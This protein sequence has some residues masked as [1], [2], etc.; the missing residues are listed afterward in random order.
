MSHPRFTISHSA[1]GHFTFHLTAANGAVILTSE[2][3]VSHHGAV[4]GVESVK[5]NAPI[6]ARYERRLSRREEPYFVLTATSGEVIG[7]SEMYSSTSAREEGIAS[8]KHSAP[9]ATTEG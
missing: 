2:R 7:T 3:Y 6:D 9:I 4:S 5:R 8:V 1:S